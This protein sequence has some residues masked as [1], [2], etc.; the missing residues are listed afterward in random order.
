[1]VCVGVLDDSSD[2]YFCVKFYFVDL[3]GLERVKWIGVD[4]MC[5]KEGVILYFSYF[6]NFNIFLFG[7]IS[8]SMF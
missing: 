2:D 1:M 4:G 3:V 8:C 7:F 6:L 5:F